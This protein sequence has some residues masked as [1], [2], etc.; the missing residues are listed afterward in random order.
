MADVLEHTLDS[1]VAPRRIVGRHPQDQLTDS[2]STPRRPGALTYVHL[3]AIIWR[4]H[5]SKVSGVAIVAMSRKAAQPTPY[6]R[7]DSRRRSSSVRR[8]RRPPS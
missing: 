8:S 2:T 6:A 1:R 4:C 5:R 3:P 7:A